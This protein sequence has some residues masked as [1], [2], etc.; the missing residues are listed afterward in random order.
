MYQVLYRKW[1]PKV[2]SDVVGQDHITSTLKNQIIKQRHS[3]AYLFTG[4]RGTGKTTCAKI[5]AKAVNCL[6]PVNGDPCGECEVCKKIENGTIMDVIEIDAASNNGVD[7]I[8]DIR[9][10]SNFS[11]VSCKYRVY[12]ID[13]VH[14]LSSG[15]FNALLKTLEEPP[16]HVKF[17]LATTE[18]HKLPATILSR[19]QRFDFRR[20]PTEDMVS[21]M[22]YI[23]EKENVTLDED[24]AVLI[25]RLSDGGMRDALSLLDQ[26]FSLGEKVTTEVVSRAAGLTG[27]EYLFSLADALCSQDCAKS[28]EILS[29][30]HNSSCDMERLCSEL[31]NHYRSLMVVKTVKSA[32]DILVC[33]KEEF[34]RT[35]E[36]SEKYSLENILCSID[37]LQD[38]LAN[39][40]KGVNKRIEMEMTVI[41]LSNPAVASDNTALL[42]RISNLENMLKSGNFTN[43]STAENN[44]G[45]KKVSTVPTPDSKT[46]AQDKPA[47]NGEEVPKK[48]APVQNAPQENAEDAEE[49]NHTPF[50]QWAE[51]V[52]EIRKTN[53]PLW[54]V[55]DSSKAYIHDDFVLVDCQYPTFGALIRQGTNA[56]D[57]KR[58]IMAV[59]GRK[60]RLG[61]Y[62]NKQS[63]E[64]KKGNDPLDDL[65]AQMRKNE[66]KLKVDE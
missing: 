18:I 8:R 60:Y 53:M 1:R 7:N 5:L 57:V 56:N 61:I 36:Q 11:P 23:A 10:E 38:A 22:L 29:E 46:S 33:T 59:T 19:C 16:E 65:I 39:M 26:C 47:E 64:P 58:A 2:F 55:L 66:I 48:K 35:K 41:K 14:M 62:K 9:Q 52:E 34:E 42:K 32:A 51:V 54:G 21:R 37:M 45:T 28:M 24:A 49:K 12:I 17:I 44:A 20:I 30:L 43:V 27:K 31:I 15:A 4:S 40:K 63:E 50:V 6:N 25:S 3:H 13:E